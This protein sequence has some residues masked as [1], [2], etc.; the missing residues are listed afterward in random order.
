MVIF[1]GGGLTIVAK[2]TPA[3]G[4]AG[5]ASGVVVGG[6]GEADGGHVGAQGGG[7]GQLDEGDVIVDGAGVPARVGEHLGV[8][9]D[10]SQWKEGD[11]L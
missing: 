5:H 1:G 4:D 6:P 9:E 7:G 10:G 8:E 11:A 3:G 2:Q